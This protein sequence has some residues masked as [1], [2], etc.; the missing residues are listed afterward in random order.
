MERKY[1]AIRLFVSCGFY[2]SIGS[3]VFVWIALCWAYSTGEIGPL[4]AI[5]G[6]FAGAL[7]AFLLMVLVDAARIMT[8]L[9][10]PQ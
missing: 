9:L 6:Y 7:G 1:Y 10:I 5:G 4:V 8:E 3:A 2:L